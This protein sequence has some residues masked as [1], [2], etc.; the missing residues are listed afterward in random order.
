MTPELNDHNFD[1]ND[2][3]SKLR[4]NRYNIFQDRQKMSIIPDSNNHARN[5]QPSKN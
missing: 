3:R 1:G 4:N 2:N 5:S